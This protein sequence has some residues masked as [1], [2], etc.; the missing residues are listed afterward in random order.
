MNRVVHTVPKP[1]TKQTTDRTGLIPETLPGRHPLKTV[2]HT[3]LLV[4][5]TLGPHREEVLAGYAKN[6]KAD[7]NYI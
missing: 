3:M 4:G 1:M 6:N 2:E 7:T 5:Y